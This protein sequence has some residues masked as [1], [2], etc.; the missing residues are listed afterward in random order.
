MKPQ[1]IPFS[2]EMESEQESSPSV[3][4]GNNNAINQIYQEI[5][6]EGEDVKDLIS[7]PTNV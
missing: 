4:Y 2:K 5:T 6:S 3:N 1:A 7:N